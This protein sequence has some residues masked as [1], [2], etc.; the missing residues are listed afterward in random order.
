MPDLWEAIEVE[1]IWVRGRPARL[2]A[3]HG[4]TARIELH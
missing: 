4:S 1:R 3:R 2:L